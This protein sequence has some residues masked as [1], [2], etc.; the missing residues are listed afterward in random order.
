MY[1]LTISKNIVCSVIHI[2]DSK[3]LYQ[4]T[5]SYLRNQVNVNP[6][7]P[8]KNVC[9]S[10]QLRYPNTAE[11]KNLPRCKVRCAEPQSEQCIT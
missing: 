9:H 10:I 2:L 3:L 11:P 7:T 5:L 8:E 6:S 4:R 1:L